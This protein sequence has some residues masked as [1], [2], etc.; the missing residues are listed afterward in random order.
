[1]KTNNTKATIDKVTEMINYDVTQ[2][3]LILLNYLL[4]CYNYTLE[5]INQIKFKG[6]LILS[7][8]S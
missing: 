5:S 6:W 1:M 2:N 8:L 7:L 4:P 3:R